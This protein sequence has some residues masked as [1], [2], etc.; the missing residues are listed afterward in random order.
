MRTF[1]KLCK[2]NNQF[3][4]GFF[5]N[6]TESRLFVKSVNRKNKCSAAKVCDPKL[7]HKHTSLGHQSVGFPQCFRWTDPTGERIHRKKEESLEARK[8]MRLKAFCHFS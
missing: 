7:K 8:L 4:V 1:I 2:N 6:S 3:L 5:A